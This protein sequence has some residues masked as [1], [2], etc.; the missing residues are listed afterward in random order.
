MAALLAKKPLRSPQH[1]PKV[2]T[3]KG[4]RAT[5]HNI[6]HFQPAFFSRRAPLASIPAE[7]SPLSPLCLSLRL[8]AAGDKMRRCALVERPLRQAPEPFRPTKARCS[9]HQSSP[10]AAAIAGTG[11]CSYPGSKSISWKSALACRTRSQTPLAELE[12]VGQVFGTS[13]PDEGARAS[14][15][16]N[17]P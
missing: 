8:R 13:D 1:R 5:H 9:T 2:I 10:H 4:I 15:L 7:L 3:Q 12:A 17:K 11:A 14:A 16:T 6:R